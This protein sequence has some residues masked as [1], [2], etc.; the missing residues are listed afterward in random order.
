[1]PV[2]LTSLEKTRENEISPTLVRRLKCLAECTNERGGMFWGITSRFVNSLSLVCLPKRGTTMNIQI[3]K[4][5][6]GGTVPWAK[7]PWHSQFWT[8]ET[9]WHVFIIFAFL[10]L[11]VIS[12]EIPLHALVNSS[13]M[14][15]AQ[16][17]NYSRSSMPC[18]KEWVITDCIPSSQKLHHGSAMSDTQGV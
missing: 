4:I 1:M 8:S 16:E 13:F 12:F 15:M 7:V 6:P 17:L 3:Q 14:A 5:P 18:W 10:S 9:E 2:S 11:W